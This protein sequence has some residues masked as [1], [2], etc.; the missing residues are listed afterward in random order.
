MFARFAW[1]VIPFSK[2]FATRP[3]V[4]VRVHDALLGRW[5]DWVVPSGDIPAAVPR[6]TIQYRWCPVDGGVAKRG[7]LNSARWARGV[8]DVGTGSSPRYSPSF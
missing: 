3:G 5:V 1:A 2:E 4:K 8:L 7:M 6:A